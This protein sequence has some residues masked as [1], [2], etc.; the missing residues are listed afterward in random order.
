VNNFSFHEDLDSWGVCVWVK[1]GCQ[2]VLAAS[3]HWIQ[4]MIEDADALAH[5]TDGALLSWE[6]EFVQ[7]KFI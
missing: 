1:K 7:Q 5:G 3:S 2:V 6:N 4:K